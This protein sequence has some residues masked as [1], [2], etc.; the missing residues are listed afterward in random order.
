MSAYEVGFGW[1]LDPP[2]Q[3]AFKHTVDVIADYTSYV[4]VRKYISHSPRD[5]CYGLF[6]STKTCLRGKTSPRLGHLAPVSDHA[7]F[8][9]GVP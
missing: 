1:L 3:K 2:W 8:E 6:Y 9:M 4:L 5:I 7:L